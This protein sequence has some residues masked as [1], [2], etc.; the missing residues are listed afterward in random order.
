MHAIGDITADPS[1]RAKAAIFELFVAQYATNDDSAAS[2]LKG[3]GA[4]WVLAGAAR[5]PPRS[6]PSRYPEVDQLVSLAKAMI[7]N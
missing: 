1:D 7:D 6:I 4:R 5:R 2:L 3:N